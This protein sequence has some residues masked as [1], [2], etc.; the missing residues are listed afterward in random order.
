MNDKSF[1]WA[2]YLGS[3]L[4]F[5]AFG[6]IVYL[7]Y[8]DAQLKKKQKIDDYLALEEKAGEINKSDLTNRNSEL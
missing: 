6:G 7:D 5:G 2:Y 1:N 8:R 3:F 4:I